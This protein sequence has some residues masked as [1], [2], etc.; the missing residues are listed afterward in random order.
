MPAQAHGN[1][2]VVR[3]LCELGADVNLRDTPGGVTAL[4]YARRCAQG[5]VETHE[6]LKRG[7]SH[8]SMLNMPQRHLTEVGRICV[9]LLH[10]HGVREGHF[11]REDWYAS[12]ADDPESLP[13]EYMPGFH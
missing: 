2:S 13:S 11:S 4:H 3:A 7:R 9:Q 1:V 5:K 8:R 12:M 10:S 6:W